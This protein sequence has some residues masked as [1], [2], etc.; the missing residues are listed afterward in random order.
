MRTTP[1]DHKLVLG[2][3]GVWA[4]ASAAVEMPTSKLLNDRH[5]DCYQGR[6]HGR[7]VQNGNLSPWFLWVVG[8]VRPS[9]DLLCFR[10]AVQSEYFHRPIPNSSAVM[11]LGYRHAFDVCS[12]YAVQFTNH[13]LQF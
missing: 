12:L 11:R 6:S 10:M 9:I 7:N 3:L 1:D 5:P 4:Y 13:T 8:I 2:S